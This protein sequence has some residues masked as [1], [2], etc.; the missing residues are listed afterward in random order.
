MSRQST[1]N[2]QS[3][4]PLFVLCPGLRSRSVLMATGEAAF[5]RSCRRAKLCLMHFASRGVCEKIIAGLRQGG[6]SPTSSL[7]ISNLHLRRPSKSYGP[8]MWRRWIARLHSFASSLGQPRKLRSF[9]AGLLPVLLVAAGGL[10]DPRWSVFGAESRGSMPVF[11][12]RLQTVP[13]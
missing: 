7:A 11:R 6:K 1:G 2:L 3:W 10:S 8:R 12:L 9:A 13:Y 4:A 5:E